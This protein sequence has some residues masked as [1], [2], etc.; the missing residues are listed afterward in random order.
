MKKKGKKGIVT[1]SSTKSQQKHVK[2]AVFSKCKQQT[3]NDVMPSS[4]AKKGLDA[5]YL[6]LNMLDVVL[7]KSYLDPA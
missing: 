3:R 4:W 7:P 6:Y 5:P 2:K 1:D